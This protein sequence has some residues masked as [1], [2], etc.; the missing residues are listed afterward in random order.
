MAACGSSSNG[1][2]QGDGSEPAYKK[3]VFFSTEPNQ[4]LSDLSSVSPQPE[5]KETFSPEDSKL[6]LNRYQLLY[7]K[8]SHLLWATT[9]RGSFDFTF[10][11]VTVL[12]QTTQD[13]HKIIKVDYTMKNNSRKKETPDN[14]LRWV[15][16]MASSP[17]PGTDIA[18]Q[19]AA[20]TID[21]PN[22]LTIFKLTDVESQLLKAPDTSQ[23]TSDDAQVKAAGEPVGHYYDLSREQQE[24]VYSSLFLAPSD[25]SSVS[26]N[27]VACT[28]GK[29]LTADIYCRVEQPLEGSLQ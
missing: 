21:D 19:Y 10:K 9:D 6:F 13:G 24:T 25:L 26:L 14:A 12:P 1:Y 20:H 11:G 15:F 16:Y 2:I 3:T 29:G 22:Q 28:N 7:S 23:F 8:D 5:G 18:K 4:D 27:F 17:L